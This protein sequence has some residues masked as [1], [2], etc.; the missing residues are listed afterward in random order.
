MKYR[1]CEIKKTTAR[2]KRTGKMV[3]AYEAVGKI[4]PTV[5]KAKQNIDLYMLTKTR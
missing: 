1:G 5:A 4:V 3:D 2:S